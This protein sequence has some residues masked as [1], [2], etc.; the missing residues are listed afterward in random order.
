MY[1]A[2]KICVFVFVT[3]YIF[4][5]N[6]NLDYYSTKLINNKKENSIVWEKTDLSQLLTRSS[7]KAS[8]AC[9]LVQRAQILLIARR[10]LFPRAYW[11]FGFCCFSKY[12]PLLKWTRILSNCYSM[13]CS[14]G[15]VLYKTKTEAISHF[16]VGIYDVFLC[17]NDFQA[18]IQNNKTISF[19]TCKTVFGDH[20][21][22]IG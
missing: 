2:D 15:I 13:L 10:F 12:S 8:W 17:N 22:A 5:T 3:V 1:Y 20:H 7:S 14:F 4:T 18:Q 9:L 6:I 19:F 11:L 21:L 16:Q